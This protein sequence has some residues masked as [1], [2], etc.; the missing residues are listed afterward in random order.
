[1]EVLYLLWINVNTCKLYTQINENTLCVC[2]CVQKQNESFH[3]L[4][5]RNMSTRSYL[6]TQAVPCHLLVE[7]IRNIDL[8]KL[9]NS[10]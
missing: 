3:A 6:G 1:M 5:K 7:I 10:V 8:S 2:V 9:K 4:K